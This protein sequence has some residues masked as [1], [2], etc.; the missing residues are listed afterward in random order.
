MAEKDIITVEA[1]EDTA[2]EEDDD[3]VEAPVIKVD[4]SITK[5]VNGMKVVDMAK[6]RK[7]LSG[8]NSVF[9]YRPLVAA[10]NRYCS[11]HKGCNTVPTGNFYDCDVQG[12]EGAEILKKVMG[13]NLRYSEKYDCMYLYN[14]T[15]GCF[16]SRK[17]EQTLVH[18]I[19]ENMKIVEYSAFYYIATYVRDLLIKKKNAGAGKEV[20]EDIEKNAL[21]TLKK[22]KEFASDTMAYQILA[23]YTGMWSDDDFE[24]YYD[25]DY[26]NFKN[27]SLNLRTFKTAEHSPE[28]K[29]LYVMGCNYDPTASCPEFMAMLDRI[30]PNADT[31]KE[32]QKAVGLT[33][34]K[35]AHPAKKALFLLLGPKDSGK[36]TLMNTLTKVFGTYAKN[37]DCSVLLQTGAQKTRGPELGQFIQKLLISSS[38]TKAN[39]KLDTEN[40]KKLTGDTTISFRYNNSNVMI[41]FNAIC[42]IFIDSNDKP[43][44]PPR[45]RATWD[46]VFYFPFEKTIIKKDPTLKSRLKKEYSGIFNWVLEGMKMILKEEE[47]FETPE[48]AASKNDF[49][50]EVDV[51]AQFLEDCVIPT[52][53]ETDRIQFR[54]LYDTYT[55]WCKDTNHL[56]IAD[57]KF[58]EEVK[59]HFSSKKLSEQYF[60]KVSYTELGLL[61]SHKRELTDIQFAKNKAELFNKPALSYANLR[62]AY[63]HKTWPWF[64]ANIAPNNFQTEEYVKRDFVNYCEWCSDNGFV[65]LKYADFSA[66]LHALYKGWANNKIARAPLDARTFA[67][68]HDD[69]AS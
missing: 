46:R 60:L 14:K 48:M 7:E 63:F 1:V 53:L 8:N 39:D 54:N 38:E 35:E 50:N 67:A 3:I 27:V 64:I 18:N 61:Y 59:N 37:I 4:T 21:E 28:L 16:D 15:K 26:L 45:D 19:T 17:K 40:I 12:Y 56:A 22:S 49:I 30:L 25:N 33:L 10:L 36:T 32:F 2:I 24:D 31:R 6:F 52:S 23:H 20:I 5:T 41:D 55:N 42:G 66:K 43:Y 9:T 65:G 68:I 11:N 13:P 51:T 44:I 62:T 34:V 57:R 29:Q 58:Y 47:L 69:W